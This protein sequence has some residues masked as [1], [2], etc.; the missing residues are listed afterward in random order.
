MDSPNGEL[1]PRKVSTCNLPERERLPYWQNFFSQKIVRAVIEP[2]SPQPLRAEVTIYALPG[3]RIIWSDLFTP[4]RSERTRQ[5]VAQ[6]G[7]FFAFIVKHEGLYTMCQRGLEVSPDAGEA[8]GVLQAEPSKWITS[9]VHHTGFIVPRQA[10]A[11]LVTNVEDRAMRRIRRDNQALRL[12]MNYASTLRVEAPFLTPELCHLASTHIRDLVAM[13]L[14]TTR[15]GAVIANSGGVRAARLK[16]IKAD[17]LENLASSNLSISEVARHQCVTPRYI[18]MLFESEGAT[19]SEFVCEQRLRRAQS[20]LLDKRFRGKSVTAIAFAAG[21][22]DLSYF[23]RCFRRR[24]GAAPSE[25]R[26]DVCGAPGSH[27]G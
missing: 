6:G 9:E 27:A 22:G 16:A 15:D 21:F 17:I 5:I 10:L 2:L 18:H 19:F 25:L 8:F 20:M 7:D 26:R 14:G 13:A 3:M 24:F 12:L 4:M 23:N 11:P 1:G